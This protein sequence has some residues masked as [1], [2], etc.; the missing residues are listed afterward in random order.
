[1]RRWARASASSRSTQV[2]PGKAT[3]SRSFQVLFGPHNGSPPRDD[4]RRLRPARQGAVALPPLRRDLWIWRGPGR[5]HLGDEVEPLEDGSAFRITPREVHIVENTSPDR[6]LAVLGIFTPAGSPSAAYLMPDVAAAVRDRAGMSAGR[7][8]PGRRRRSGA[9]SRSSSTRPTSTRA[10]RAL[11]R[12]ASAPPTRSTSPAGTRTA[13]SGS[14]GSS[15]PRRPAPGSPSSCTAQPDEVAVTTSVSQGV[16]GIVS[17]LPFERGGR[18]RIVISEYEFPTV[19][20]IAHAQELRGAEVV[21]VRPEPD[22]SIPAEKFAEAIDERTALVC[23]TTISYRTGHRHD[24]AAI[25]EVAHAQRRARPRRQLPGGGRDRARRADARR[26]LRHGRHGEVPARLGRPRLPLGARRGARRADADPDRLVRRRGHLP[27][28]H[29]RLLAA[30]DG[31]A[32]RRGNAAGAE[33]L[34]GR[35]GPRPAAGDGRAGG[36]GARVGAQHAADRRPRGARRRTSSPRPTRPGAG[37]SSASARRTRRRSSPRSPRRTSSA[38][39]ATRTCGWRRTTT[40]PTTTSTRC[41]RRS[42]AGG[43]CSRE[44]VALSHKAPAGP[45]DRLRR[46]PRPGRQP[47]PAGRRGR[48]V[49]GGRPDPRRVLEVGLGQDADDAARTRSRA[50]RLRRLEHRVPARRAGGRRLAG[51]ARGRRRRSGRPRRARGSRRHPRRH[52]RPLG[53]RPSRALARRA[54]PA[55]GGCTRRR[56]AGAA[57]VRGGLAGGGHRSR[58]GAADGLG[59]GACAALLGGKPGELP[60]RYAVASPAALL[61]LGVLQVLVHGSRDD[62]VPPAQSRAY[63]EAA[64]AAGDDVELVEVVGADHFDVIETGH[65]AWA[66]VV[67]RLPRLMA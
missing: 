7:S 52:G 38:R 23:C 36:R 45:P 58:R 31:P 67:N 1:M 32:L 44:L 18:N 30:R 40:T 50:P 63:A 60:E 19:G 61:P 55:R 10:R 42:D 8:E 27:D 59:G 4:V 48:A 39:S 35:R 66:A 57:R 43:T 17:A 24:V 2:E 5:Y 54:A 15:G 22:G 46:P 9:S 6:E 53:R 11:S 37:R 64:T 51:D 25:A 47:A 29:L 16:S 28:G 41:S 26:R 21:H 20:Q 33:H 62:I 3:G 14:S 65:A 13:P 56:S 34:R 49:A 12:I